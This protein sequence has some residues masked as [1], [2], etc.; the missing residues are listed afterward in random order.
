MT[1]LIQ[2]HAFVHLDV[3]I[4]K[5]KTI[6]HFLVLQSSFRTW[7]IIQ[8]VAPK[9][10]KLAGAEESLAETMKV[11]NAKRSELKEVQDRLAEL[12]ANFKAATDKKE[13]LEYQVSFLLLIYPS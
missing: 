12:Q 10:I 13:Q 6:F 5:I 1:V 4:P 11:L 8:V 2:V 7:S 3:K 9:K